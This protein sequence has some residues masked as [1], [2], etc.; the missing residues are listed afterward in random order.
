MDILFENSYTRTIVKA[1]QTENLILLRSKANLIYIFRKDTF[2]KGTHEEFIMF[3]R[4][5]G[6]K[7][8]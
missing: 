2:I 7:I 8:K 5:K 3:L 4:G 6:I 1:V